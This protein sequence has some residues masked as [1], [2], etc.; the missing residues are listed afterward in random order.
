VVVVGTV[1]VVVEGVG[2]LVVGETVAC[3]VGGAVTGGTVVGGC[4]SGGALV[5]TGVTAIWVVDVDA[6]SAAGAVTTGCGDSGFDCPPLIPT[7][8]PMSAPTATTP[9]ASA[10]ASHR[11]LVDE[12]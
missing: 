7:T 11:T 4:V 10:V 2:G 9:T 5:G 8:A 3:V 1:T 6:G 12:T